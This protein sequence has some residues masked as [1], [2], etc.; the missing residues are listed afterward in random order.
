MRLGPSTTLQGPVD[1]RRFGGS[2]LPEN[3]AGSVEICGIAWS[4]KSTV[5]EIDHSDWRMKLL[6][7]CGCEVQPNSASVWLH[8]PWRNRGSSRTVLGCGRAGSRQL[9][10]GLRICCEL[11]NGRTAES[12]DRLIGLPGYLLAVLEGHM[13]VLG[14]RT[15]PNSPL[16]IKISAITEHSLA[17]RR[18][19]SREKALK[20]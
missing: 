3:I 13:M 10:F 16:S 15:A 5:V 18:T 1:R 8:D 7:L 19:Q 9:G 4:N 11:L 20:S 17:A 2:L 14:V 12:L 6:L